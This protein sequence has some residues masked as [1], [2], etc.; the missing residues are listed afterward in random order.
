M[1]NHE[2]KLLPALDP[3]AGGLARLQAKRSKPMQTD[4]GGGQ[5]LRPVYLSLLAGASVAAML[6]VLIPA[7]VPATL[8]MDRLLGIRSQGD[9]LRMIE[10]TS[11][12]Q[13]LPS[14]QPGVRLYWTESLKAAEEER[15]P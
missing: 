12:A 11:V 3:P 4:L 9:S 14:R 8:A 10:A 13:A 6:L 2:L 1:P 5:L 7:N 15:L